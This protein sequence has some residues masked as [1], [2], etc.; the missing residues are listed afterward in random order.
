MSATRPGDYYP[1]GHVVR[2]LID[3]AVVYRLPH[4]W[5]EECW[6]PGRYPAVAD[7]C[8]RL[9]TPGPTRERERQRL[10]ITD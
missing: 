5:R 9:N 1:D 8:D 2:R 4:P 7:I 6:L 10:G 3:D